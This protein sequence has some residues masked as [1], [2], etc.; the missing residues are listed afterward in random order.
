MLRVH[1]HQPATLGA[2]TKSMELT[3]AVVSLSWLVAVGCQ[4]PK[5]A[6]KEN[7][8]KAISAYLVSQEQ[9]GEYCIGSKVDHYQV[10]E[11]SGP[12]NATRALLKI[13]F[14]KITSQVPTM[15]GFWNLTD[16][17]LTQKGRDSFTPGKGFCLGKPAL[18][19]VINF[20][21]PGPT[22]STSRVTYSYQ[23]RDVPSWASGPDGQAFQ[24]S[25][26]AAFGEVQSTDTLVLTGNGWVHESLAPQ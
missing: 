18:V 16:Y 24:S 22:G 5:A 9:K 14:L 7:F 2:F 4:N 26:A 21:D 6:N 11:T 17:D 25:V 8:G 15:M 10:Q 3:I 12:D 23:L 19:Q 20:T 1:L 13:G